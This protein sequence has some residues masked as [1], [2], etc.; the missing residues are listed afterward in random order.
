LKFK[1]EFTTHKHED[2]ISKNQTLVDQLNSMGQA[3]EAMKKEF[4]AK[5]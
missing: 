2:E 1:L 5:G 4:E 3:M